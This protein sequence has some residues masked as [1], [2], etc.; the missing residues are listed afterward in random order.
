MSSALL[1]PTT[2][3]I[4]L[5]IYFPFNF[6]LF[7]FRKMDQLQQIVNTPG[8]VI[9][10]LDNDIATALLLKLMIFLSGIILFK[11]NYKVNL[12]RNQIQYWCQIK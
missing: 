9:P 8:H 4:E 7:V 3:K 12:A 10:K 1:L 5:V 6:N 11:T 2:V